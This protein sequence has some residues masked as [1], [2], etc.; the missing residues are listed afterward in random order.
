M[1]LIGLAT[2][3]NQIVSLGAD[4]ITAARLTI[5]GN[6]HN[7]AA[8]TA[9]IQGATDGTRPAG[10]PTLSGDTFTATIPAGMGTVT[11]ELPASLCEALR[12]GT[13]KGLAL[14]GDPHGGTSGNL[15]SW[16]LSIDFTATR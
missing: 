9:T 15:P 1:R 2:Y 5:R 6:G 11:V 4:A 13:V 12:D 10:A 16:S 7:T 14:M 8:W 3:G